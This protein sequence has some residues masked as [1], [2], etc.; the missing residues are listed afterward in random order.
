[1]HSEIISSL[2]FIGKVIWAVFTK[3]ISITIPLKENNV[4]FKHIRLS[5]DEYFMKIAKEVSGRSTCLRKKVGAVLVDKDKKYIIST[6]YNGAPS[7]VRNCIDAK[8]CY[9]NTHNIKSGTEVDRCYAIHAEQNALYQAGI[10]NAQG[11]YLYV[12]GH[13]FICKMCSKAIVQAGIKEVHLYTTDGKYIIQTPEQMM[14]N[15]V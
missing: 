13:D 9:R 15:L 14:Q 2:S 7:G 12:Y 1:M 5:K 3:Q 6:G 11:C 4:V 10:K 8:E